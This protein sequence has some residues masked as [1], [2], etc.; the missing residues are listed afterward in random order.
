MCQALLQQLQD[1]S[2]RE[3]RLHR[4]LEKKD[5]QIGMVIQSKFETFHVPQSEMP[6]SELGPVVPLASLI[7][8][9]DHEVDDKA[10]LEAAARA[11]SAA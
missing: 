6:V 3:A 2:L 9:P 10:F 7:D 8:V 1:A 11:R 5:D 4:L